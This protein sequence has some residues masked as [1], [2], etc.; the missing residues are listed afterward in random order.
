MSADQD[1]TEQLKRMRGRHTPRRP[2]RRWLRNALLFLLGMAVP[3]VLCAGQV[4]RCYRVQGD[5]MEPTLQAGD[6]VLAAINAYKGGALPRRG[7]VVLFAAPP[8][9]QAGE[10]ILVKRV[11]GLPG[12]QIDVRKGYLWRNGRIVDEPYLRELMS[13]EWTSDPCPAGHVVVLGDN[14]NQS[15]DSH[16]WT[17]QAPGSPPQPAPFVA[18]D[19][20]TGRVTL[21]FWP[22]HRVSVVGRG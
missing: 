6:R 8:Q 16:T 5:A 1:H 12:D 7:D 2:R 9:A 22:L 20:L 21:I 15:E 17:V 13:F 14:R 19:S 4:V 11:V 10:Q 3:I 18:V